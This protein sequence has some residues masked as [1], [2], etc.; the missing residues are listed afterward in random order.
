MKNLSIVL[1]SLVFATAAGCAADAPGAGGGDDDTTTDPGTGGGGDGTGTKP[2]ADASGSYALHSTFDLSTNMPGTVGVVVNTII[3]ATDDPEDPTK[4]VV[5]LMLSKMGS[6][7]FKTLLSNAEP[8]VVGYL[9]DRLLDFAPDF[10]TTM[11]QLGADFG[12]MAKHFGTVEKLDVTGSGS[13]YMSVHTVTGA[14]LKVG[15][16]EQDFA[17]SSYGVANTV[18]NGVA[19]TVNPSGKLQIADHQVPMAYGKILRIGLDAMI[20]P[21]LSQGATNLDQLL[22]DK[23]DCD[24][25]GQAVADAIGFG[26]ASTFAA[27]CHAGL[28]AGADLIY[29]KITGIDATALT[30]EI[31]GTVRPVDSNNDGKADKLTT[32]A[33]TGMLSYGSTPSV[34]APATFFGERM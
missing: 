10:V 31:A 14:H 4:W 34:L 7:T 33:W 1:T 2:V 17:F 5:D 28:S 30:F 21:A 12:D 27:G 32:G 26:G 24:A 20:I 25:V 11:V 8:F 18:V 19:V 16:S 23:V 29:S 15:T 13:S 3:D 6:G 9:N 22:E